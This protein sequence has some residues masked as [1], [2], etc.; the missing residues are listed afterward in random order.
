[1]SADLCVHLCVDMRA[2]M[3]ADM[4]L[5]MCSVMCIDMHVPMCVGMCVAMR[6]V[7]ENHGPLC[8]GETLAEAMLAMYARTRAYWLWHISYNILVIA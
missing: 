6:N 7:Q 8:C 2:D 5:D 3:C 4:C 1:M